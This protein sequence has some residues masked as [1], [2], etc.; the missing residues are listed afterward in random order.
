MSSETHPGRNGGTVRSRIIAALS[1][2][3]LV[4]AGCTAGTQTTDPSSAPSA[5]VTESGA[6]VEGGPEPSEKPSEEPSAEET[7]DPIHAFGDTVAYKTG[8][9][10]TVGELKSFKPSEYSSFRKGDKTFVLFEVTI[11]NGTNKRYDP[12]AFTTTGATGDRDAEQVFDSA[13]GLLGPPRS[14]LLKGRSKKF[15]MAYGVDKGEDFVLE[16]QPDFASEAA[17]F[18]S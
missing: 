16:V 8:I 18:S 14:V 1:V 10:V 13:A 7:E 15:K 11:K 9:Q 2:L 5:T 3:A 17:I 12:V 4:V 6:P